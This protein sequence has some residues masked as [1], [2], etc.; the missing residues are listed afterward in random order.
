M[1][2]PSQRLPAGETLIFDADD[3]LW[4]NNIY[5]ERATD[6]FLDY[7]AHSQLSNVQARAILNE[8]Q[9][10]NGYGTAAFA[11]SLEAAFRHHAERDVAPAHLTYIHILAREV[12]RHPL[13][14]L[15]GVT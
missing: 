15:P 11:P 4:E 2:A 7:L 6:A 10:G 3:T 8:I 13:E 14:L 1:T 5:F 12:R 9:R